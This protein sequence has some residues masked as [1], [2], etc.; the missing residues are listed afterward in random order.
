MAIQDSFIGNLRSAKSIANGTAPITNPPRKTTTTDA[1]RNV[2]QNI[3]QPTVDWGKWRDSHDTAVN[4]TLWESTAWNN[5]EENITPGA[6]AIRPLTFN[7]VQTVM[8]Y[9][10]LFEQA[11]TEYIN[12][13]DSDK[14]IEILDNYGT[15]TELG[16]L[17]GMASYLQ[18]LRNT[19]D[20]AKR[21]G[22]VKYKYAE[23]AENVRKQLEAEINKFYPK[24]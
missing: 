21:A 18:I 7:D 24:A 10:P 12:E 2:P 9:K 13:P 6:G 8:P 16:T 4:G 15:K 5:P 20:A 23:T 17:P 22:D 19:E 1:P 14:R 11:I 3:D